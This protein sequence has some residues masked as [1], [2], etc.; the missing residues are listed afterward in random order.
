MLLRPKKGLTEDLSASNAKKL[1]KCRAQDPFSWPP[2]VL[3]TTALALLSL[4]FIV[5]SSLKRQVDPQGCIMS[6]MSPTYLKLSGFDTE[7]SR[8]ASKYSLYLYREE[9]VDE[10]KHDNIGLRGAPVLFIP[11]NAGSY[12]QVR[13]LSS[14]ASRYYYNNLRHD[15]KAREEG[16]RALD[17]FTVDFNEDLAAFHGQT[18]ID[19]AEYVNE[20]IAY[21]LS[22][23]HDSRR[24]NRDLDL[25][26]PSSVILIGHSMGGIVARTVLVNTKYQANSV[27][28]IITMSTPHARPPVSF[29]ADIV[30]LYEQINTYWRDAYTQRWSSNNPLWQT[31]LI[32]IAG[33]GRDTT[34]PSDYTS[35]SSLVPESHGF[36][37]F[38]STVPNVW[39]SMD[40]LAITWAD[41]IRKAIVKSLYEVVDVRRAAQTKSRAARM[42]TF[43]KWFLTGLEPSAPK[44]LTS[45]EHN[46][47]LKL[48][49]ES[50][51]SITKTS[52]LTLHRLGMQDFTSAKLLTVPPATNH[53]RKH[54]QLLTDQLMHPDGSFDQL[55]ILFCSAFP[56]AGHA[57][58]APLPIQ[59]D[60]SSGD[61]SATRLACKRAIN[62]AILLPTSTRQS[63]NAFDQTPPFTFLQYDLR[64]L[65]DYQFV[66]IVDKS[67]EVTHG[68]LHAEFNSDTDSAV[69]A[70]T[71]L[72]RLLLRGVSLEL[73]SSRSLMTDIHIPALS[74]SLLAYNLKIR[75]H[76]CRKDTELFTPL[77]RQYIDA[78]HESKYFVNFKEGDINL[79]GTAPFMPPALPGE[80]INSGVSFQIWSDPTC[81]SSLEFRLRPD[82]PGSFGKL[83]IRYRTVFAAF[84][85]LVVAMV[86]RKQFRLYDNTGVFISFN[87]SLEQS[88]RLPLPVLL[89]SM[90]FFATAF[91]GTQ[92]LSAT[93]HARQPNITIDYTQ[94]D[95]L[96]GSQDTFFWFLVPLGG[97][98]SVGACVLLN[99]LILGLLQVSSIVFSLFSS[100]NGYV[101]VD[102]SDKE[103]TS[104]MISTTPRR[105][106]INTIVL[107]LLV[108]TIIPYPFAYVVACIVQFA[109]TTRALK[110]AKDLRSGATL[111]FFN[112]THSI[113]ILMLW[114]LPI[115]LPVLVVWIHNLA[116]HWMTP[117]SSHHNV[118]SI[119]PFI[120]L[121]ETVSSGM[122]VPTLQ[123]FKWATNF[124]FFALA[125]YAAV[126]GMT[127]AYRLHYIANIIALW[128]VL[129][130]FSTRKPRISP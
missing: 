24:L 49:D 108:A 99:Y 66:A 122:M 19:Q 68:W 37:V 82:L 112:Y 123:R 40:H 31:T 43:R 5:Q 60:L 117:F 109:T 90:T 115:N 21:I 4:T 85:L 16:V 23:Y 104:V 102:D 79:H 76:G 107:L 101:K 70:D 46:V 14:E 9:G 98:L 127:Y 13:S 2:L 25:P 116:V 52:S 26:D 3:I 7:H 8:F 84:P 61:A 88:L 48:G 69:G 78:P 118:L 45:S 80:A 64:E 114:V 73:P 87:D 126:Y 10:Y 42:R 12:K 11:G 100:S 83:V 130:H 91:T 1:Q 86:L 94:N 93:P 27:N 30:S 72:A 129:I 120:L 36:T 105:R 96:L 81:R 54:F 111:N 39:T 95:L 35:V 6:M 32:S 121:V 44:H 113:L 29:D 47:L 41:Q 63:R 20:A 22:L 28:T 33:G 38:T 67:T 53:T 59:I 58:T 97:L 15:Q 110:D 77:V 17:F 119:M 71:S 106:V 18:V 34:V 56:I 128:L 50:H 55:E 75:Q 51:S 62:D 89:L 74:S 92:P 103:K 125:V 65:Q 57:T 124:L